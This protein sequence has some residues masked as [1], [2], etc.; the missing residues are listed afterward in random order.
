MSSLFFTN[1]ATRLNPNVT[2]ELYGDH[3]QGSVSRMEKFNACAFSHFA[4]HGLK[5]KDRQ[6]YK[7]EAPDI[8]QLFHSA[9]K[10]ISD[11]LVEQKKDWKNLTKEDCVT[12][13]RHAIEQ[14]APRLQKE[15][16]LSSNRHAYIKEKLQKILIRVSSI[17]SEH[18]KVSG[19]SPVGLEL[20][21]GGQGPLPPFT[22]QLKNGRIDGACWKD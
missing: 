8:G 6:F 14:L 19:F 11:T 2:K 17:L 12:Y 21:F 20:G 3:I 1:R 18:A 22:F 15:I 4:S 10:L 13:S 5:L 16:L 9:L 7:L